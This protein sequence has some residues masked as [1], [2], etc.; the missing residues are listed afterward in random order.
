M[1]DMTWIKLHRSVIDWEWYSDANVMRL[2]IHLLLVSNHDDNFVN[3]ILVK[4]GQKLT[5]YKS[6]SR[7]TG[8]SNQQARTAVSKLK[9]TGEITIKTFN[10]FSIIQIV[11]YD[12]FQSSTSKITDNQQ[13]NN[14]QSNDKITTNKNNKEIKEKKETQNFE[15]FGFDKSQLKKMNF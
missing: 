5:S 14:K 11:N 9:S 7:E 2:F 1:K 4:R 8:L 15:N 10:K 6:I 3:G 12:K 13:T